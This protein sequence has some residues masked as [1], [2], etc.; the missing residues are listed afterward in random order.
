MK[1]GRIWCRDAYEEGRQDVIDYLSGQQ[2]WQLNTPD[3]V[4]RGHPAWY[5]G[6]NGEMRLRGVGRARARI[7]RTGDVVD[8]SFALTPYAV[9]GS[10]ILCE[11]YWNGCWLE[12]ADEDKAFCPQ[13][14]R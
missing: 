2:I 9:H 4:C 7:G 10:E 12:V 5:E 3:A 14:S 13:A 6:E 8:G 11:M 1:V